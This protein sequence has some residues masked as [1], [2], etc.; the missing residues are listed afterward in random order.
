MRVLVVSNLYPPRVLGGYELACAVIVG[1]LIGRRHDVTV[2]TTPSH[3][4]HEPDPRVERTLS[5]RAYQVRETSIP[6][7]KTLIDH[8]CMVSQ[9]DNSLLLLA[10]LR[11]HQPDVVLFFNVI[12]LGAMALID[13]V[14]LA[15]V[16]WLL[17]LGDRV[18][19]SIIEGSLPEVA[20]VY[21]MNSDAAFDDAHV[22]AV[23][24]TLVDEIRHAGVALRGEVRVIPRGFERTA[25]ADRSRT[26]N[27]SVTSFLFA[28]VLAPHKGIDLV[29]EASA[30]LLGE[31][32]RGFTVS[33]YGKGDVSYYTEAIRIL[34]LQDHVTLQG[35]V[36]RADLLTQYTEVDAVLFPSVPREPF[37][38]VPFEA[39]AGGAVPI[40]TSTCGAAEY[41]V[42]GTHALKVDRD[43]LAIASCMRDIIV[44]RVDVEHMA[45]AGA[46]LID[47]ALNLHTIS[48][49][50]EAELRRAVGSG[51]G[52]PLHDSRLVD[53][54][55]PIIFR[56]REALNRLYAHLGEDAP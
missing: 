50:I 24:K 45:S 47:G 34:S 4:T 10:A 38:S 54:E 53:L 18:P 16:P 22:I 46:R 43:A 33:V 27:A 28:G 25:R 35:H 13:V 1:E 7:I 21:G 42:H 6:P 44:G 9:L 8:E 36:T 19:N 29:L 11:R 20:A 55:Q 32:V 31:G 41:L 56:H 49:A 37:G 51:S 40:I 39:I 14:R 26:T 3:S 5:M 48:D 23:S 30:L 2:L 52:Q 17:N 12:G 15:G